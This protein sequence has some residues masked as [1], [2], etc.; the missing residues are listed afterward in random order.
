M[1]DISYDNSNTLI[2]EQVEAGNEDPCK[3]HNNGFHQLL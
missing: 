3:F 1:V 2:I